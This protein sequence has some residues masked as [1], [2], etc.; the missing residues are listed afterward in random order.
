[1]LYI[2]SNQKRKRFTKSF[3]I[4]AWM[5]LQRVRVFVSENFSDFSLIKRVQKDLSLKGSNGFTKNSA[6]NLV[7]DLLLRLVRLSQRPRF[8]YDRYGVNHFYQSAVCTPPR[9]PSSK[10]APFLHG[11]SSLAPCFLDP[12]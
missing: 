7:I 2:W 11:S 6:R 3:T 4:L 12:S 9:P 5:P 8:L 1:M 10:E